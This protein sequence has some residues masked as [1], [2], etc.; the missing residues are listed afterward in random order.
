MSTR[1]AVAALALLSVVACSD[2][3]GPTRG[4]APDT[5]TSE[6]SWDCGDPDNPCYLDSRGLP[7]PPYQ[8]TMAVAYDDGGTALLAASA[9]RVQYFVNNTDNNGW[10]MFRAQPSTAVTASPNAKISLHKNGATGVGTLTLGYGD[11]V[12]SV[13]LARNVARSTTFNTDCS[14]GCGTIVVNGAIFISKTA[15]IRPISFQLRIAPPTGIIGP[16]R[17]S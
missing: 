12:I 14:K 1:I 17:G 6:Y 4:V 11:G 3:V 9:V 7:P 2:V 13:D 10:M 8:D 16:E 5:R 15:G